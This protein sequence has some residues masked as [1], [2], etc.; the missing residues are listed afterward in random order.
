MTNRLRL[1]AGKPRYCQQAYRAPWG[2][3]GVEMKGTLDCGAAGG[4]K[5]VEVVLCEKT[6]FVA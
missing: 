4:V 2:K 1:S 3:Y 5:R 6:T